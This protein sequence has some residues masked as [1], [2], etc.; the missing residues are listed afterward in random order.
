MT[1]IQDRGIHW[2]GSIEKVL[3]Y[4]LDE[5]EGGVEQWAELID[6]ATARKRNACWPSPS[7]GD[8]FQSEYGFR[9]KKG[10]YV[11]I[12]DRGYVMANP[13][14]SPSPWSA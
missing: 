10:H 2:S 7:E 12:L 8:P 11:R 3:G 1:T 6:P 9:H 4:R 13:A 5:M 14:G